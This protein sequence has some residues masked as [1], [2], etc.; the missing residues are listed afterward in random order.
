MSNGTVIGLTKVVDNGPDSSRYNLV[1][2]AEGYTASQLPDFHTDVSNFVAALQA[3][4]PYGANWQAINVYRIDVASTDSGAADPTACG[5]TGAAPATYFDASFCNGGIQRLLEVNDTTVHTVVND[6]LPT[7][8]A[9]MVLVNSDIYGGSETLGPGGIGVFSANSESA[10]IG[11]HELGH[12][13]GLADEYPT[14]AGCG[15]GESGHNTYT[16]GEP[17]QPNVTANTNRT[18]LKWREFVDASTA[19]PTTSNPNCD[20]CDPRTT[21]PVPAGTVGAFE[22]AYYNHCGAYRPEFTCMM[23]TLGVPYCTVCEAVIAANLSLYTCTITGISEGTPMARNLDTMRT[24]RDDWLTA[25][26]D[27]RRLIDLLARHDAEIS[28]RLTV[29]GPLRERAQGLLEQVYAVMESRD[30][31]EPLTFDAEIIAAAAD[32]LGEFAASGSVALRRT[33]DS[34]RA[35][36]RR[37]Q[38]KSAAEAFST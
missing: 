29:D 5:G 30:S 36:L 19:I 12:T 25:S 21:S 35:D 26:P 37:L 38:G 6:Y 32:V 22:G 24:F 14:W 11:L 15:S 27:G 33:A 1:I 17:T 16:G 4:P 18:T 10:Q 3:T 28:T 31:A 23:Q 13:F 8:Q 20:D 9:I 2:L 7:A 34:S